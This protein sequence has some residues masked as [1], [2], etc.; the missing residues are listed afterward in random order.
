MDEQTFF[1][2]KI[3]ISPDDHGG[4]DEL[5]MYEGKRCS[6]HAEMMHDGC[7]WIAFYPGEDP[8]KRVVMWIN[9]KGRKLSI[10]AGPD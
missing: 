4:F 9:A 5:F 3:A 8:T 7:L 6:V 2:G 1:D 10:T